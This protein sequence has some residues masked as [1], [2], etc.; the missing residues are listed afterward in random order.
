[1]KHCKRLLPALFTLALLLCS[2]T[3]CIDGDRGRATAEDFLAAVEVGDFA[4]AKTFLHPE[5]PIDLI[6]Y[7]NRVEAEEQLD[8][9]SGVELLRYSGIRSSHYHS[10]VNG[11]RYEM[12]IEVKIG[13]K[14]A[15]VIL[16]VVENAAGYGIYHLEVDA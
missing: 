1:M 5:R 3:S 6:A 2:L 9:Q 16:E 11:S 4:L 13:G 8:F 7:C 10:D 14:P 12:T 15:T